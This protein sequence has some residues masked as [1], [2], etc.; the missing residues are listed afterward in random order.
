MTIFKALLQVLCFQHKIMPSFL[1][2]G[3]II[4]ILMCP[5]QRSAPKIPI[6]SVKALIPPIHPP[7]KIGR[8]HPLIVTINRIVIMQNVMWM[9]H[10][11]VIANFCGVRLG[12]W[13]ESGTEYVGL[14]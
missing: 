3:K 13:V 4:P 1:P 10:G 2:R 11:T 12:Y 7:A 8:P 5:R 6:I 9:V 14:E